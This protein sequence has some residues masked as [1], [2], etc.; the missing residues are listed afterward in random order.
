M[1]SPAGGLMP[2]TKPMVFTAIKLFG[3]AN[4]ATLWIDPGSAGLIKAGAISSQ[5]PSPSATSK[6]A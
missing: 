1:Q 4:W 6:G 5:I 3:T 2:A